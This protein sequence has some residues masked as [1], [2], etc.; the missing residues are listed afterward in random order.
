[1]E[2]L[3]YTTIQKKLK[4]GRYFPL[5]AVQR[6]DAAVSLPPLYAPHQG[7]S[8][9]NDYGGK[10]PHNF[11]NIDNIACKNLQKSAKMRWFNVVVHPLCLVFVHFFV[12]Y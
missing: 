6:F 5:T 12:N 7:R 11:M 2:L 8:Q 4:K 10:C 1:M 9:G 3:Y